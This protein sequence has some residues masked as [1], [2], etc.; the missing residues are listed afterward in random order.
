ME[1]DFYC[2]DIVEPGS[3]IALD[4]VIHYFNIFNG[5]VLE[6]SLSPTQKKL[7][8]ILNSAEYEGVDKT[9]LNE[10]YDVLIG[11]S[12]T[13]LCID[14]PVECCLDKNYILT[15]GD[16]EEY[17]AVKGIS[18]QVFE[19]GGRVC[20]D[21]L[22]LDGLSYPYG[23]TVNKKDGS[24]VYGKIKA[25]GRFTNNE[26]VYYS[27]AGDFYKGRLTTS[28]GFDNQLDYAG[29]CILDGQPIPDPSP[30]PTYIPKPPCEDHACNLTLTPHDEWVNFQRSF[31]ILGNSGAGLR[32]LDGSSQVKYIVPEKLQINTVTSP[33]YNSNWVCV[34]FEKRYTLQSAMEFLCTTLEIEATSDRLTSVGLLIK[35]NESY[36]RYQ[37]SISTNFS[38]D[39]K[40]LQLS[41]DSFK[42]I[43]GGGPEQLDFY[44]NAD[45]EFGLD[46]S[47]V[48]SS[49][50]TIITK[51]TLCFGGDFIESDKAPQGP[52]EP[53]PTP[54]PTY[55][56]TSG[57]LY[58]SSGEESE[59]HIPSIDF[60]GCAGTPWASVKRTG[61][62][63]KFAAKY[64]HGQTGNET[65]GYYSY[66]FQQKA[67]EF[68]GNTIIVGAPESR[69]TAG[70]VYVWNKNRSYQT[71]VITESVYKTAGGA[72]PNQSCDPINKAF[73]GDIINRGS[74][75]GDFVGLNINGTT[76]YCGVPYLPQ[77]NQTTQIAGG[78]MDVPINSANGVATLNQSTTKCHRMINYTNGALNISG[79]AI[80][81]SNTVAYAR[82]AYSN[83][84]GAVQIGNSYVF[85]PSN[86]DGRLGQSKGGS[87]VL[88]AGNNFFAVSN[89]AAGVVYIITKQGNVWGIRS[90]IS[91][92]NLPVQFS[93]IKDFGYN[94]S[95]T[96]PNKTAQYIGIQGLDTNGHTITS[97]FGITVGGKA[98]FANIIRHGYATKN[99][100][101]LN[102]RVNTLLGNMVDVYVGTSVGTIEHFNG[103]TSAKISETKAP[104]YGKIIVAGEKKTSVSSLGECISTN[105]TQVAVSC[106]ATAY[107]PDAQGNRVNAGNNC[108][109]VFDVR[110]S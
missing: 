32:V 61:A 11:L 24:F 92:D 34:L 93:G 101:C 82:P 41:Q 105:G 94:L 96:P 55:V 35:Q 9:N 110:N 20:F 52:I 43:Y 26:I 15:Y 14:R 72:N 28:V 108:F 59:V 74:N 100:L 81:G 83:H 109:I 67:F 77:G 47:S 12:A 23:V 63:P 57:S 31:S 1:E 4:D 79:I 42:K 39:I 75:L 62:K 60:F 49:T 51:L 88:V 64:G 40:E 65:G 54:T 106:S 97:V 18:V 17:P 5:D 25:T 98:T 53:T 16:T 91:T 2:G 78:Y 13:T 90:T 22:E 87:Q 99:G 48:G 19:D 50:F 76:A 102:Q 69:N 46:F 73:S 30:T 3:H 71:D 103:L 107:Q 38:L 44:K 95:A 6:S 27:P 29:E 21:D 56:D 33:G 66:R 8:N 45:F 58:L 70:N 89:Y 36:Y 85:S 104:E 80:D 37:L 68:R 10:L 86:S 84:I 7:L